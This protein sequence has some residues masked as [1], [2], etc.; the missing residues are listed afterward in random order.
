MYVR[1]DVRSNQKHLRRLCRFRDSERVDELIIVVIYCR[2]LDSLMYVFVS[3]SIW[4][5]F[6][7]FDVIVPDGTDFVEITPAVTP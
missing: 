6:D 5:V 7:Y 4:S 2:Q 3:G 1:F